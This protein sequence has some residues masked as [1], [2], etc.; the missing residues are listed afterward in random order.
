MMKKEKK[1]KRLQSQGHKI[2]DPI[3]LEA[4]PESCQVTDFTGE[5]DTVAY[6]P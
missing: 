2:K 1:Q 5:S 4:D 3:R 6:A